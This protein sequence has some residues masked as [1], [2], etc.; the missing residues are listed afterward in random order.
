M[1]YSRR[2]FD[3]C[4]EVIAILNEKGRTF[5]RPALVQMVDP[6]RRFDQCHEVIAILNEKGRTF[7]R[8]AL[9]FQTTRVTRG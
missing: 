6:R 3:Q 4:H 5:D 8:P 2:R 9:D 7:D 1:A